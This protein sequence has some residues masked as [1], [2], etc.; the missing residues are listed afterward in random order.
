VLVVVLCLVLWYSAILGKRNA[1]FDKRYPMQID[2][3]A[4]KGEFETDD[5]F[6]FY[7]SKD[8]GHAMEYHGRGE[9]QCWCAMKSNKKEVLAEGK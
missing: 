1:D 4:T 2:C 7:A 9:Y 8:K 5:Q 3:E 6:K